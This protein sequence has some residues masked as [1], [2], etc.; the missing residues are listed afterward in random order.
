[1]CCLFGLIDYGH[2][3]TAR[4]KTGILAKLSVACEAR[5]TDAAG[6]AY[7]SGGTLHIDKHPGPARNLRISIPGDAYAVMGHTRMTTQGSAGRNYNN[8]PFAGRAGRTRFALAHNGV[9]RNDRSLRRSLSLPD[10]KIETDSYVGVQLLERQK[11]L[12]FDSLRC[13]AEQVN[14]SFVF[15]V[16]DGGDNLYIVKG[17]N[18]LCLYHSAR[19]GIYIYAS[20][21]AILKEG[22]RRTIL[23]Q[24][25]FSEVPLLP[26]DILRIDAAGTRSMGRFDFQDPRC[27][28][29]RHYGYL[30]GRANGRYA[31]DLKALAPSYGL[32]PDMIETLLA[33]GMSPDEIE[34]VFFNRDH[35][36]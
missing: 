33:F 18:P 6:I 25:H 17:D 12:D 2:T 16:L 10:T 32:S 7:N 24:E 14:G 21:E 23:R 30:F 19:L 31:E 3:L 36:Y 11:A 34:E 9:L 1:M 28:T 26:G 15:T 22:L 29:Y 27:S 13:M 8:H 5:G 20:T 35:M 4:Q